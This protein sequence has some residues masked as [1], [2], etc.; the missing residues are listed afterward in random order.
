MLKN[1][2]FIFVLGPSGS[3]KS[4]FVDY[5]GQ[6]YDGIGWTYSRVNLDPGNN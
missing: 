5:L 2:H 6:F 4:T 3:G 1:H